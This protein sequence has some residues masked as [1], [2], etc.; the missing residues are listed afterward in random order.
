MDESNPGVFPKPID[1]ANFAGLPPETY[2]AAVVDEALEAVVQVA[3]NEAVRGATRLTEAITDTDIGGVAAEFL[4]LHAAYRAVQER[5][6]RIGAKPEDYIRE[7][8]PDT[9]PVRRDDNPED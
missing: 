2:M 9:P 3:G 6:R 7:Q 1:P 5:R 4:R 8:D